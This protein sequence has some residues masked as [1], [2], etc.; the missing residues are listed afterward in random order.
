MVIMVPALTITVPTDTGTDMGTGRIGGA[1]TTED[2]TVAD[3]MVAG[4]PADM[5]AT[6]DAIDP[7]LRILT[8]V[9]W[10]ESLGSH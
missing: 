1:G 4:T 2:F 10:L 3:F 7:E 8:F 9:L 6:S 5:V